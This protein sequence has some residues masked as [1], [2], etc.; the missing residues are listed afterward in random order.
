MFIHLVDMLSF[1]FFGQNWNRSSHLLR[2]LYVL[3]HSVDRPSYTFL[4]QTVFCICLRLSLSWG[5]PR[6]YLAGTSWELL[7]VPA[8]LLPGFVLGI[9]WK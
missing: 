5:R 6:A 8:S 3:I 1:M 9:S 2:I 7:G 4:R